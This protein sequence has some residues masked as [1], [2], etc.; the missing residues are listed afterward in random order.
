MFGHWKK[1][2]QKCIKEKLSIDKKIKKS[3]DKSKVILKRLI[4]EQ[5]KA[6]CIKQICDF[7]SERDRMNLKQETTLQKQN[8]G[9]PLADSG[10]I[11]KVKDALYPLLMWLTGTK[12]RYR[13]NKVNECAVLPDKPTIFVA[14]HGAFQ[15]TPIM[16]RVT[17]RRSYIF[18]G[19]QNLAFI[20]WIFFVLNGVIWVD[21]KDKADMAASK[22][23][24]I[25]YLKKGQ[26]ILW[27]PEGTWNLT[28]NQLMMP[29]K[30]GIID[31]AKSCDAQIIPAALD[32]DREKLV[33]SVKFAPPMS[34][35]DFDNKAE[36]IR[37]LR[38]TMATMRWDFI[39][40]QPFENRGG[41]TQEALQKEAYRVI[42]EYPPLDWEYERSCIY[43]P[44]PV[45]EEVFAHLEQLQPKRENAFLF[46][47]N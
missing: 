8:K 38:D 39:S 5:E 25:A 4:E 22:D 1:K 40:E 35:A 2:P 43:R 36:A 23:A 37:N 31:I 46:R 41:Y 7:S 16:L 20:D 29:M 14:N 10:F 34:G 33:C 18:S 3:M 15:D 6:E 32:Y 42:D 26:S 9:K 45:P 12:V 21:R 17:G 47:K 11:I 28:P 13:I 19:K 27:F 24:L 44:N 30:W